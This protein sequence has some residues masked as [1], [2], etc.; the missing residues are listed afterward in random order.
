MAELVNS[1]LHVLPRGETGEYIRVT[2]A[3]AGWEHLGF[4]AR[5]I[6]GGQEWAA[7]TNDFE[8]GLV[9]LGGVCDVETSRGNWTHIGRRQNVFSGMPFGL[10]L[11]PMMRNCPARGPAPQSTIFLTNSGAVASR[12]LVA[13]TRRATPIQPSVSSGDETRCA[14]R[15]WARRLWN[16]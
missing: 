14:W 8:Y 2:P 16:R 9:I 12:G 1:S 6:R 13:R 11:P 5:V 4:A 15:Y 7:T 3:S 10:F